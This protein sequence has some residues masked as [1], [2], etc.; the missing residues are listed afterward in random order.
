MSPGYPCV[1]RRRVVLL[2]A[3]SALLLP[4][5]AAAGGPSMQLGAAEDAVQKPTIVQAKAE[6]DLLK[7]AGLSSVRVSATW[8]PGQTAPGPDESTRLASVLGAAA[9]DAFRVYV[10]VS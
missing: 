7:L 10:S 6:L 4:G 8:A 9:L 1:M 5:R 3:L 2:A